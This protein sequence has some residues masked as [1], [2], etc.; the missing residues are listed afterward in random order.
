MVLY[1]IVRIGNVF[2]VFPGLFFPSNPVEAYTWTTKE[3]VGRQNEK[4]G[5]EVILRFT[6]EKAD[7]MALYE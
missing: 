4:P 2:L 3:G 5:S 6:A 1:L 7:D